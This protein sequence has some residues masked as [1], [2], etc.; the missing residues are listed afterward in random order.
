MKIRSNYVSNSSSS[1]FI[2]EFGNREDNVTISGEEISMQDFLDAFY[3][4]C[5]ETE[6]KEIT[7]DREDKKE[8]IKVIDEY[9][10]WSSDEDK[11]KLTEL[12]K[13]IQTSEKTFARFDISY[14]NKAL[15]FMFRLL[16]KYKMFEIR[17]ETEG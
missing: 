15:N 7:D 5:F 11:N 14:H 2:I 9:I 13:D 3:P 16:Y 4:N 10:N 12:K 17:Y 8:L 6:I 1:S